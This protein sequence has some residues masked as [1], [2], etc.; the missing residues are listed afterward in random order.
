MRVVSFG[1]IMLRLSPPG[2]ERLFQ[3]PQL[4]TYF[5]GAEANVAASLARLGVDSVYVSR[6]P[7]NPIGEAAL[8]ELR[9]CGVDT[10]HVLKGGARLGSYFVEY[11]SDVRAMRV[12]YDRAGSAFSEIDATAIAWDDVLH[13]A[14]WLHV[15]GITPAL[16][17]GAGASA[18]T[19]VQRARSLGVKVSFDL[20]Y[21]AQLWHGR[22]P[23]SL[24]MPFAKT[25]DLLIGNAGAITA[26]LG[27]GAADARPVSDDVAREMAHAVH[28]ETG[29]ARVVVTRRDSR[30]ASQHGWCASLLN[31]D[32]GAYY[33]SRHYQVEVTDR[34][35]GGDA[36]AAGL[37]FALVR[38]RADRD[39]LE[40][41]VA[42]GAI[43]LTIN[44]DFSR[45]TDAEIEKLMQE[46]R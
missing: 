9:S 38:G 34:V 41:G 8:N 30:S 44:G 3:S 42:A 16:G 28:A 29:S 18:L 32:T 31:G 39:V 15:S 5:G 37:L 26:M 21:R 40:Y 11:G 25:S 1:E 19:A 4:R 27:I 10:T 36:C 43:K 6:V 35:G 45:A 46:P 24:I 20:N 33:E 12:V 23:R 7:D 13:G 2:V 14:S 17:A 22:D